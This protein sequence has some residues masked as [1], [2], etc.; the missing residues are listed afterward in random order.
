[1][2]STAF[3]TAE[4]VAELD[5]R[6]C[7]LTELTT[8]P[9]RGVRRRLSRELRD[10]AA[11]T[12]LNV[13]DVLIDRDGP[14]D[15]F[16]AYELIAAHSGAVT[17]LNAVHVRR[18]GRAIDS[19]SDVDTF[20]RIIAGPAWERGTVSD[21]EILRWAA[22]SNRWWRRA[23]VV[24]TVALNS[25]RVAGGRGDPRR[26]LRICRLARNDRDPMVVKA[27]SWA[28]RAL[29]K[30]SPAA[31]EEFL[32]KEGAA[33]PALVRREVRTK[34]AT[35]RKTKARSRA[36]NALSNRERR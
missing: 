28:L 16:I 26:T 33:L 27:V 20:A 24:S 8:A 31:V 15:R 19:W 2:I 18:L 6:L 11:T 22:S 36:V 3:S 9:V 13:A 10:T 29:A 7:A 35:G 21:A 14:A 34:L 4:I 5:A 32:N 1:V 25:V 23:A 17:R 30:R 12:V